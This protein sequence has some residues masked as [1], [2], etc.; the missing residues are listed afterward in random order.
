MQH[1]S[2]LKTLQEAALV[3]A[4]CKSIHLLTTCKLAKKFAIMLVLFL[5]KTQRWSLVSQENHMTR[6]EEEPFSVVLH[7]MILIFKSYRD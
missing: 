1:A 5:F 7:S 2:C 6:N 4:S 3:E